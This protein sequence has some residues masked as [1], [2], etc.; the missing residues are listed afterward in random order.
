GSCASSWSSWGECGS[1]GRVACRG[2]DRCRAQED[3]GRSLHPLSKRVG[4]I[5]V[6]P[7]GDRAVHQTVERRG[8]VL[9]AEGPAKFSPF[10]APDEQLHEQLERRHP[11]LLPQPSFVEPEPDLRD[12]AK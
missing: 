10:L 3:F 6:Q 11:R 7:V 9:G 1:W 8:E 2:T 5:T 12:L 4:R